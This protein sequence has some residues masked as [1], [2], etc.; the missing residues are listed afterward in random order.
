MKLIYRVVRLF[1]LVLIMNGS[2]L[3]AQK[4]PQPG[5]IYK[6]YAVNL[7]TGNNW[8]V[9]DPTV[10]REDAKEFLP[11]PVLNLNIDDL[12]GA[13]RAEA[14]IDVWGGHVGT[15]DKQFRFNGNG[16]IELPELPGISFNPE[17]Y[18]SQYNVIVDLPLEDLI[19]GNNTFEGTSGGQICY[20]FDWGQWGWWVM[21]VRIYYGPDKT[22]VEGA[23]DSPMCNSV[24][25]DDPQ[26]SVSTDQPDSVSQVQI[27]G[28]YRGY[29]ENGDGIYKD[30]HRAYHSVN[31]EGHIGTMN[32]APYSCTWDTR[33]VPDQEEAGVSLLARIQDHHG[34]WFVTD[35][36]DSISL[37]RANAP[38][39]KMY[40]A[41]NVPMKFV[42]RAGDVKGCKVSIQDLTNAMEAR[43]IHR[44]WNGSD[45]EAARG[46][47]DKPLI[48]NGERFKVYGRSHDYA[49]STVDI[50]VADLITGGNNI[51]YTSDT[52][53]HGIEILWPGPSI[54]IRHAGEG[55]TVST[56]LIEPAS[57]EFSSPFNVTMTSETEGAS[58]YFTN[59]G[60]APNPSSKLYSG[61]ISISKNTT[62][63]ARSFKKD[64]FESQMAVAT[65]IMV[66]GE[67][68]ISVEKE[69]LLYPNPV[70]ASFFLSIPGNLEINS[71]RIFNQSGVLVYE[72]P[73]LISGIVPVSD[74]E[75]G[76]YYIQLQGSGFT[77]QKK[78]I[79][80]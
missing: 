62:I 71:L 42:V 58:I 23:I 36:V 41:Y 69:V 26:I 80:L 50:P 43:L 68:D 20:S 64:L 13:I 37:D 38:S 25:Q 33:Y 59:D 21:Q 60:T 51:Q 45:T 7:K 14:L 72:D 53:H 44:T 63:K 16:W 28:K 19:E 34:V 54:I 47:I 56:P 27:L 12:Q 2:V 3:T 11:N 6:E 75:P 74:L 1:G 9:T 67:S 30:W 10:T 24:I 35:I 29:D 79:I 77:T 65:Y 49:L 22:H 32:Q 4:G 78:L 70:T 18:M 52:E 61:A 8:R 46:S 76:T 17:C 66:T 15:T 55:D 48:I 73:H 31:P 39:V 57:K 40:T 5:D